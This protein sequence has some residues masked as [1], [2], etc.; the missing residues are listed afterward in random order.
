MTYEEAFC[1]IVGAL[2][3]GY[4]TIH[5]VTWFFHNFIR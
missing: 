1:K 4:I 2:V 3:G 5:L